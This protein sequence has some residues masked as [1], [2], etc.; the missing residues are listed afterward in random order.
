MIALFLAVINLS[1]VDPDTVK[2][3][4][5]VLTKTADAT[6]LLALDQPL[7][8]LQSGDGMSISVCT[9]GAPP[10]GPQ[11]WNDA[12]GV[13]RTF[14]QSQCAGD[15][16]GFDSPFGLQ[17]FAG[18]LAPFET[19]L[20]WTSVRAKAPVTFIEAPAHTS[21]VPSFPAVHLLG[22]TQASGDFAFHAPSE[23]AGIHAVRGEGHAPVGPGAVSPARH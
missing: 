23:H 11:L 3:T 5:V 8:G 9:F 7:A 14:T 15:A 2:A 22:I 20:P 13:A 19:T 17:N 16:T 4:P 10:L 18:A 12:N 21:P 1:N 6:G